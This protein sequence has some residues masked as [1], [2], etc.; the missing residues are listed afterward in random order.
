M[1]TLLHPRATLCFQ[2]VFP[3]ICKHNPDFELFI[4]IAQTFPLK[5]FNICVCNFVNELKDLSFKWAM[6]R[7][8]KINLCQEVAALDDG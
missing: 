2:R 1:N 4:L 8:F 5:Q 3:L 6:F 7:S